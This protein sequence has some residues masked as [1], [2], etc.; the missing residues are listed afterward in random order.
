MNR[1]GVEALG[2][3][4][5]LETAIGRLVTVV[6]VDGQKFLDAADEQRLGADD[7]NLV[8]SLFLQLAQRHAVTP[9]GPSS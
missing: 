6:V 2:L 7:Q 3:N 4:A 5:G 8:P 1:F 9:F